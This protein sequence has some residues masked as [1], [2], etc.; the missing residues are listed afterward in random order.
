MGSSEL[1]DLAL[2]I[3]TIT[4]SLIAGE[5]TIQP[6]EDILVCGSESTQNTF[7]LLICSSQD[8]NKFTQ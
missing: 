2:A 7:S 6:E 8:R 1:E 4:I 3:N 5:R